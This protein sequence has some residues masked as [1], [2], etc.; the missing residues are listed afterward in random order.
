[1]NRR[2]IL[3]PACAIAVVALLAGPAQAQTSGKWTDRVYVQVDAGAQAGTPGFTSNVTF[4]LNGEDGT[5]TARYRFVSAIILAGRAGVRVRGNL[6]V[7]LGVSRFVRQGE[8][9]V[10][11]ALPHPFFF[12]QPRNVAGLASDLKREETMVS[13]ELAWLLRPGRKIDV[14][15]FAGPAYFTTHQRMATAPRYTETYPYDS[16]TF[17]GVESRNVVKSGVGFT[18][19]LDVTC[20]LTR[21]L[22]LGS[23]I[24]YSRAMTTF[25]AAPGSDA[26][27]TLGGVQASA[28]LRIRF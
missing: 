11:A 6:A 10:T 24:R 21:H 1:M 19:G 23:L 8:A 14:M 5:F 3:I 16:A 18:A 22:G 17:V 27:A 4:K 13:A 20:L 9:Q 2:D 26:R 12:N 28:G 15:L 25:T 7:G